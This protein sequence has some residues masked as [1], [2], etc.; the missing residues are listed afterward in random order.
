MKI[1]W[2]LHC[3]AAL[4]SLES[5]KFQRITLLGLQQMWVVTWRL[6]EV[7]WQALTWQALMW[8]VLTW[9]VEAQKE[10]QQD[11]VQQL[12]QRPPPQ[13]VHSHLSAATRD[14]TAASGSQD[15]C[16]PLA[17]CALS[18]QLG[19]GAVRRRCTTA[20]PRS[21]AMS[22]CPSPRKKHT[23]ARVHTLPDLNGQCTS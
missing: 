2:A 9:Q 12:D 21:G 19:Y 17:R 13:Q 8:K 6:L 11:L 18:R 23:P 14:L 1:V 20:A 5:I 10:W 16:S 3:L 4:L 7:T 22:G 15:Y